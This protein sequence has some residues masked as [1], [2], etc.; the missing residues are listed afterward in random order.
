M[1]M[2]VVLEVSRVVGV[3]NQKTAHQGFSYTD[4]PQPPCL[5]SSF[6]VVGRNCLLASFQDTFDHK[7]LANNC[8]FGPAVD[9]V[10]VLAVRVLQRGE[11]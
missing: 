8:R 6:D 1:E 9:I 3:L 2:F 4:R 7:L 10:E 5:P 11:H